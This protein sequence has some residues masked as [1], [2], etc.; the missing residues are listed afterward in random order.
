MLCLAYLLLIAPATWS[1]MV[2]YSIDNRYLA[3]FAYI[4]LYMAPTAGVALG[5]RWSETLRWPAFPVWR[6]LVRRNLRGWP[7][8]ASAPELPGRLVVRLRRRSCILHGHI[9]VP[10]HK[11]QP[12][13]DRFGPPAALREEVVYRLFLQTALALSRCGALHKSGPLIAILLSSL[14]WSGGHIGILS[15]WWVKPLL[16]FPMGCPQGWLRQKW[17]AEACIA[18]HVAINLST[19]VALGC[20]WA[21]GLCNPSSWLWQFDSGLGWRSLRPRGRAG[22]SRDGRKNEAWVYRENASGGLRA[23]A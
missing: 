13:L 21:L 6:S 10:Y 16:V 11:L 7:L 17:G 9:T 12:W 2:R 8:V 23:S 18:V 1:G 5:C 20:T 15:P 14:L 19:H 22:P 4:F 3:M